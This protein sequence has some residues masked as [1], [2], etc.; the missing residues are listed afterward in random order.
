MSNNL[1]VLILAGMARGIPEQKT[2]KAMA[3]KSQRSV[4][5]V[6]KSLRKLGYSLR[7]IG[8]YYNRT[9]TWAGALLPRG[10][11]AAPLIM[12]QEDPDKI[13]PGIWQ[14]AISDL[15]WWGIQGRLRH[16]RLVERFR[17]HDHSWEKSRS[18]AKKYSLSK[19]MVILTT[20][21]GIEPTEE[22][23]IKWFEGLIEVH[24]RNEILAMINERQSLQVSERMFNRIWFALELGKKKKA[25]NKKDDS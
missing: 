3:L 2:R 14:E 22:A 7:E 18:F 11:K 10:G 8:A 15:S 1:K 23:M 24:T 13:A 20:S 6:M 25:M 16:S 9:D 12:N 21:F 5:S 17:D 19:L 4:V